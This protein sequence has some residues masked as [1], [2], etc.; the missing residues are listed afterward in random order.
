MAVV[1]LSRKLCHGKNHLKGIITTSVVGFR[2]QQFLIMHAFNAQQ[3]SCVYSMFFPGMMT[4]QT[5][6]YSHWCNNYTY[7][8]ALMHADDGKALDLPSALAWWEAAAQNSFID[9]IQG[10]MHT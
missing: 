1:N 3:L 8:G 5:V 4:K 7:S 9:A 6:A 2:L 10:A